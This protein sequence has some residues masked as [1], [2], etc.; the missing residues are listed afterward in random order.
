M[1]EIEDLDLIAIGTT[2]G[3]ILLYSV[4]KGDIHT[5]FVSNKQTLWTFVLNISKTIKM[6][7]HQACFFS[8]VGYVW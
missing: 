4:A 1:E 3:N 8:N 2:N 6:Y 7:R 5:Q